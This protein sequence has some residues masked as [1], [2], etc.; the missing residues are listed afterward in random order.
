MRKVLDSFFLVSLQWVSWKGEKSN[1][2]ICLCE[3]RCG[4]NALCCYG[5][6]GKRAYAMTPYILIMIHSLTR[7]AHRNGI[8]VRFPCGACQGRRQYNLFKSF[9]VIDNHTYFLLS[10]GRHSLSSPLF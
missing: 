4:A 5:C 7:I 8:G 1:A 2:M 10:V 6:F 3:N 9:C